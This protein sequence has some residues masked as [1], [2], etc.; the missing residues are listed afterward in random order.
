MG[1]RF[2]NQGGGDPPV[3]ECPPRLLAGLEKHMKEALEVAQ[4]FPQARA[5]GLEQPS[6][7]FELLHWAMMGEGQEGQVRQGELCV[8]QESCS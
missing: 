7:L 4:R 8:S 1:D 2:R 5:L 6:R 3:G